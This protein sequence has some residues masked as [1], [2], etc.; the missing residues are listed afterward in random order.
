MELRIIVFGKINEI[1]E[2]SFT[3]FDIPDTN[4][5]KIYLE[6]KF[7]TLREIDYA[8]AVEK[9][10]IHNNTLLKDKAEVALLPPFSG[11]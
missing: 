3:V 7:P 11:G 9:D 5:L 6:D 10:I 4:R 2:S 1:T 8:I